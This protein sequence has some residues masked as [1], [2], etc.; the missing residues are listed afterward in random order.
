MKIGGPTKI[1]IDLV[2]PGSRP[3]TLDQYERAETM[4]FGDYGEVTSHLCDTVISRLG[5]HPEVRIDRGYSNVSC[6]AYINVT[7]YELDDDGDR[8]EERYSY[9]VRFS[10]HPDH[11]GSD[12]SFDL[13]D[14]VPHN[15]V[16]EC[17]TYEFTEID[18][19]RLEEMIKS[20]VAFI[21]PYIAEGKSP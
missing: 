7:V 21:Q 17:G 12:L 16:T 2:G 3:V 10:D 8:D 15:E 13:N 6:S 1:T 5:E 11:Y 14:L 20:A 9:K 18:D 4:Q 19:W